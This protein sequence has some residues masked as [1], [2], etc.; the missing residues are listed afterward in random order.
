V[1]YPNKFLAL[2]TQFDPRVNYNKNDTNRDLSSLRPPGVTIDQTRIKAELVADTRGTREVS[3]ANKC[4]FINLPAYGTDMDILDEPDA[5]PID[6]RKSVKEQQNE[7]RRNAGKNNFDY[8]NKTNN[9]KQYTD[10]DCL[11]YIGNRTMYMP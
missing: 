6:R 10:A 9:K 1:M 5:K 11:T 7:E 3:N 2:T 8:I 4:R